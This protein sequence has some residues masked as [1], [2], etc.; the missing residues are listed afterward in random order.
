VRA[1]EVIAVAALAMLE[2]SLVALPRPSALTGLS[3]LRSPVWAAV[4]PGS[5]VLGTFAPLW[6]PSLAWALVRM[7]ALAIPFVAVVGTVRVARG[8]GA[9]LRT[10]TFVLPASALL[11]PGQLGQLSATLVTAFGCLS[12]GVALT[13]LIPR[14]WLLAGVV[15]MCLVDVL[16]LVSSAGQPAA[17]L[18]ANAT[19]QL[20]G[21]AFDS[22]AVGPV[23]V[24]F[25]DL[26]LAAVVGGYVAGHSFQ[27]RAA[28]TLTL[29]AAASGMLLPFIPLVPET[30][31]IGLT[32]L[33][34]VGW[35]R[36]G[37]PRRALQD[38]ALQ[39]DL[40]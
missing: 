21:P 22:A 9:I 40:S 34:V 25:P 12:V 10:S 7:A 18:I 24:D 38:L 5:I 35:E 11:A 1:V 3:R 26:V 33:L 4:L 27:H 20:H 29:L 13:R 15:L 23:T 19:A 16:L 6:Q 8:R 39:S 28:L 2:G 36:A 37:R 30:V 31:P 14:G 32:F 17:A